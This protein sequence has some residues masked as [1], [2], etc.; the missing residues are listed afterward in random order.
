MA[1]LEL[2][3]LHHAWTTADGVLPVLKGV[4]LILKEGESVALMAPSGSG[5]TTLLHMAALVSTPQQG[6]ILIKGQKATTEKH[7][8]NLRR[9][10][11]GLIFQDHRLLPELKAWENVALALRLKGQY[12]AQKAKN[13]LQDLGLGERL[14]HLP[15]QLSGG[16]AQRTAIARALVHTPAVIFAD[17][18]TGALDQATGHQ[19][20]EV[21]LHHS[22]K[23]RNS[24]LIATHD[25][26]VAQRCDRIVRLENGQLHG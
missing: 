12:D 6:H 22:Q 11:I 9:Q 18:P 10:E 8:A 16:E 25:P 14:H 4:H 19:V 3:N 7:R 20:L 2:Q 1:N 23:Y 21:L 5:K 13:L 15:G 26:T 17:E 24:L